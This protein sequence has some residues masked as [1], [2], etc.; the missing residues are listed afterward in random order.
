M[1]ADLQECAGN[2]N[3]FNGCINRHFGKS[4]GPA[5]VRVLGNH[6]EGGESNFILGTGLSALILVWEKEK[7]DTVEKESRQTYT[8]Y[9]YE[10]LHSIP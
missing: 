8:T 4:M 3:T 1:N 9:I 2:Y 6:A 5:G 10:T 7:E